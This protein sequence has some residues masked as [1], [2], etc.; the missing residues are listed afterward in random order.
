MMFIIYGTRVSRHNLPLE[1]KSSA[2]LIWP[3]TLPKVLLLQAGNKLICYFI[4]N[5]SSRKRVNTVNRNRKMT[6]SLRM[7]LVLLLTVLYPAISS[8]ATPPPDRSDEKI[9]NVYNW[10]DYIGEDTVK[11]FEKET[12]IKVNYDIFDSNEILMAKLKA[13]KSG[14]DIVM[15]SATYAA[16]EINAKL[17]RKI[18][19]SKLPNRVNLDPKVGVQIQKVD[20]GEDYLVPWSYSFTTV[21]INAAKVRKALGPMPMPANPWDL[22]FD[23]KYISKL[24]S[25]GVSILD[26]PGDMLMI[27]LAYVGKDPYS[28]RPADYELVDSMT[29]KIR[30][31]VTLFSADSYL[32]ELANGGVCLAVGWSGDFSIARRRARAAKNGNDIVTLI[33]RKGMVFVFD[34]MAIPVDAPHYQ[35]ALL[36]MNYILR[37]EVAAGISNKVSTASPNLASRPF[38]LKELL[39]DRTLFLSEEDMN[40]ATPIQPGTMELMRLHSRAFTKF[41][42]GL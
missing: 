4:A 13:G 38:I 12:G 34:A 41:K 31:Y 36:W 19:K 35:N 30:P 29:R 2:D 3:S 10:S 25:C 28:T 7:A 1:R 23:Q 6:D 22:V 5:N 26:S 42:S 24:A 27:E 14:Y 20:P 17:L 39:D 21:A 11:N 9:L 8:A 15:P 18:D 32:N 16:I 37:P 40:S 33:P